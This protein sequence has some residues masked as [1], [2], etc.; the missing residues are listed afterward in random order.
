M[1]HSSEERSSALFLPALRAQMGD[2]VYYIASVRMEDLA[3]RVNVAAEIHNSKAL[4]EFI[5]RELDHSKHAA[6]IT[7]YLLNQGQ[8]FFNSLVIGV[9]GGAPQWY[10]LNI[11]S[12][13]NLQRNELPSYI[14][15]ILGILVLSGDEKL[16]AIDGQHR[17]VGIRGAIQKDDAIRDE[18]IAAL[19][20]G[21]QNDD[22]GLER[23]RRLFTTLNRY[24]KPVNKYDIIALDE[25]DVVA[26]VTRQLI[27][28]H[29]LFFERISLAKGKSIPTSDKTSLTNVVTL[30]DCLDIYL[31]NRYRGW[32]DYKR[33]RPPDD[34]IH[35]FH[36]R[37][38][39]L[40]DQMI[41][42][43]SPLQELVNSV[44][45]ENVAAKYRNRQGGH[46]L[47]RPVGLQLCVQALK[48]LLDEEINEQEA[49][50]R[51]SNVPMKLQG[52]PWNGLLWNAVSKR[53]I[54]AREN[55]LAALHLLHIAVGGNLSSFNTTQ[56]KLRIELAGLLNRNPEEI[57]LPEFKIVD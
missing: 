48:K 26:I 22:L 40:W 15:G 38:A 4:K 57:E 9:Y 24:A 45:S 37:A 46:L 11:E 50:K 14:D 17:L 13:K 5:Q 33:T 10:E 7:E 28:E 44:P 16:F 12:S 53:M 30:Y 27:D 8:R 42:A 52:P 1:T 35:Q 29:P 31:R 32:K 20:V 49:L 18:E 19:F 6:K 51:I 21:H 41:E 34:Q 47:Y 55:Q 23:T 2:W 56:E 25:D 36:Q 3:K 39:N 43:F 54:T